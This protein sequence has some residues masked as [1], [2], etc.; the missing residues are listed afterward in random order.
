MWFVD[1]LKSSIGKKQVMGFAGF[2]LAGFLLGHLLGNFQL[3]KPDPASAQASYNAYTKF[4]TGLKPLIWIVEGVLAALFLCHV[5]V[6]TKLKLE[7]RGAR[8]KSRYAVSARAGGP[9]PASSTM[10]LTGLAVLVFV[11]LHLAVFKFG[12]HYL[13]LDE[14]G[15]VIRDMWLTTVLFLGDPLLMG[16]YVADLLVL[17]IHLF[18]ALPSFCR[19]FGLVHTKW[20]RPFTALGRLTAV[21]LT[22]GFVGTA[23][24]T[25]A[26]TRTESVQAQIKYAQSSQPALEA[27][28]R[29][30]AAAAKPAIERAKDALAAERAKLSTSGAR[31]INDK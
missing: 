2:L 11:V 22:L 15:E 28:Q 21:F 6:A 18:H 3:L 20:T 31:T 12:H 5:A 30:R 17:G 26:L 1:Y 24:G 29:D 7:N 9:T 27:L 13:Y 19:T 10:Y 23:L 4:L 8:G 16:L 25:F 14:H